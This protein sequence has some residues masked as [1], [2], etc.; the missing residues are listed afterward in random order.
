M[1]PFL[2][3]LTLAALSVLPLVPALAQDAA[4]PAEP[5][6]AAPVAP[7][8]AAPVA[9]PVSTRPAAKPQF[10]VPPGPL[11]FSD[12]IINVQPLFE[13]ALSGRVDKT[14]GVDYTQLKGD[15]NLAT[16]VEAMG[17]INRASFP[18]FRLPAAE[19]QEAK[20][21]GTPTEDS[22]AET[23]LLINAYNAFVLKTIADAYPINSI[24]Q[25]KNFETA[26]NY[27]IAGKV[28]SLQDLKKEILARDPRALFALTNGTTGGPALFPRPYTFTSYNLLMDSAVKSFVDDPR[29][30]ELLRID[31]KVT[32]NPYLQSAEALFR[33]ANSREKWDGIRAVLKAYTSNRGGKRY[34]NAGDYRI[35]FKPSERAINNKILQGGSVGNGSLGA[36]IAGGSIGSGSIGDNSGSR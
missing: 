36:P 13:L 18:I 9:P 20:A 19:A 2:K 16:F 4:S 15:K 3:P 6:V 7:P 25:I 11:N 12:Y 27:T 22:S 14:G 24:D 30:V 21:N 28:L 23:V 8:V 32:L 1:K 5:P 10:V 34:F 17:R 29:N 26:K 33:P 35:V 31:N